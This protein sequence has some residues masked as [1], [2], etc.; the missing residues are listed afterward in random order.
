MKCMHGARVSK[1]VGRNGFLGQRGLLCARSSDVLIKNVFEPRAGHCLVAGVQQQRCAIWI[2]AN[3][4]RVFGALQE[5]GAKS[6]RTAATCALLPLLFVWEREVK[7]GT[8]AGDGRG[9]DAPAHSFDHA[10]A[11]RKAN[12][13]AGNIFAVQALER[14]EYLR[15]LLI[16]AFAVV[17]DGQPPTTAFPRGFNGNARRGFAS[18][19]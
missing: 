2:A 14:L 12:A 11:D 16:K 8:F 1:T 15:V 18:V 7:R 13:T 9:P 10:L 3:V 4:K 5:S 6:C 19:C 17:A